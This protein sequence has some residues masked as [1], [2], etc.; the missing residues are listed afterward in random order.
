M[1]EGS[2]RLARAALALVLGAALTGCFVDGRCLR[3]DDCGEGQFCDARR[4]CAD[5]ECESSTTCPA[6]HICANYRCVAAGVPA[7]DFAMLDANPTSPT[8]GQELRLATFRDKVLA[9]YFANAT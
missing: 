5:K 8:F 4:S 2:R 6:A 9:L 7:P 3:H 1:T